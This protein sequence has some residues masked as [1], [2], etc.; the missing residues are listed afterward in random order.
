M[1]KKII[2]PAVFAVLS[3][4]V[5]ADA[6][7]KNFLWEVDSSPAKVYILGS[8]HIAKK[9]L[10]P[11]P[12]DIENA[13]NNSDKL[14]VEA[15]IDDAGSYQTQMLTMESAMMPM[16]DNLKNHVS[17]RTYEAAAKRMQ[18]F[19]LDMAMFDNFRPWFAATQ[20]T[21][22]G[23]MKL[24]FDPE[25]GIDKYFL[26]KAEKENK[27]IIE[28]E[29]VEYQIKLM[30]GLPDDEQDLFLFYTAVDLD[31]M[32]QDMDKLLNIWINGDADGLEGMIF[33]TLQEY[34]DLEPVFEKLFY[35]RNIAMADKI[36]AFLREGG[37]YFVIVGAG[38]LVGE[39]GVLKLLE[40]KGYSLKQL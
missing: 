39:K 32:E 35:Q 5:L 27:G 19:G 26:S 12:D 1:F 22:L 8:I 9:E 31:N 13:F 24:G 29:G 34:P 36:D 14:A 20:M 25:Y 30:S 23:L 21:S 15:N 6:S 33:E 10:Y 3:F 28:L 11:L 16:G 37:S 17:S 4:F 40:Q 7:A 38:H 2:L 18:S